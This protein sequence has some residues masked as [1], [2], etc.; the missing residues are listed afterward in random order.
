[1]DNVVEH[2][3]FPNPA[4]DTNIVSLD[5]AQLLVKHPSSTFFMR[6]SGNTHESQGIFDGDIAVVDRALEPR[7]NDLVV[8]W[9]E[10]SFVIGMYRQLPPSTAAWGAV[11]SIIHRYHQ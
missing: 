8:W 2:A 11:T 5:L 6:V 4:T 10:A 7:V 1:M 9:N 3:G